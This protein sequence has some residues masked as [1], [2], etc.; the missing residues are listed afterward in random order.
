M[1]VLV[2]SDPKPV[3]IILTNFTALFGYFDLDAT[4]SAAFIL[5]M[6]GFVDDNLPKVSQGL[7]QAIKVLEYLSKAGNL[8][9]RRRLQEIE[10]FCLLIW[11]S[12]NIMD[13]FSGPAVGSAS[14]S[15]L[16][17]NTRNLEVNKISNS[18]SHDQQGNENIG[19]FLDLQNPAP[20]D[21]YVPA[22][23]DSQNSSLE[24]GSSEDFF[25]DLSQEASYIHSSFNDP[26]L[27][28]TGVDDLDWA[29][30]AKMFQASQI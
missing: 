7:K 6:V 18:V 21:S 25:L 19:C 8:V 15:G 23:T 2:S 1:E 22:N 9:A 13:H 29:E 10:Q 26:E 24:Y 27:T 14:N 20:Q 28:L 30:V 4:F 17:R 5:V 3:P 11:P 12:T 16:D